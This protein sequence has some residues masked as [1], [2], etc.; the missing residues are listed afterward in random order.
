LLYITNESN[1]DVNMIQKYQDFI[2]I[3]KVALPIYKNDY[4]KIY[5]KD[6]IVRTLRMVE[7]VIPLD[8]SVEAQKKSRFNGDWITIPIQLAK[9]KQEKRNERF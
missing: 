1:E 8:V 5:I 3:L 9:T 2:D 6:I 7:A 4:S